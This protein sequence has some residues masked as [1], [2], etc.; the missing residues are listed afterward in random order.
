[1]KG[2]VNF[3]PVLSSKRLRTYFLVGAATGILYVV[4]GRSSNPAYQIIDGLFAAG[5]LPLVAGCFLLS[6]SLGSF[7]LMAYTQKKLKKLDDSAPSAEAGGSGENPKTH[8][9][10]LDKKKSSSSFK[11][12]LLVGA[13]FCLASIF[14]A[15]TLL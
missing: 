11:E 8:A 13:I 9:D 3:M 5:V 10:D 1:M 6:K 2:T 12:P 7:D 15:V 4:I 14:S